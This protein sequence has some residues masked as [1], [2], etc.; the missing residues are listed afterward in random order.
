MNANT[1]LFANPI[2]KVY[3]TLPPP[4]SELVEV[5]AFIYTGPVQPTDEEF[6]KTPLLVGHNRVANALEWLKLNH[7]DYHDIDISYDNL[8][9]YPQNQPPVVMSY[10]PQFKPK[11]GIAKSVHGSLD[12]EEGTASGPCPLVVHGVTGEQ[13]H[14]KSIKSL[15]ALA[16]KHL[17][18]GG[19][20]MA[21]GHAEN[22]ESIYNNPQLYPQ[23]FPWLFPY[24]LGGIA[25]PNYYTKISELAHKQHLLMYHDKR[26]QLDEYFPIIAFN[27]E[28]NKGQHYRGVLAS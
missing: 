10:N 19:Q 14:M 9:S 20:V 12:E 1:I 8:K 16:V 24:G 4:R 26:F 28:Q 27:H 11:E 18:S 15:K 22:L 5:L 25:Q 13:L 21:M 3:R 7:I 17:T 6:K 2:P 23:I